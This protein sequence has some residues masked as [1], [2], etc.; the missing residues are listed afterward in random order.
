MDLH[1]LKTSIRINLDISLSKSLWMMV[2]ILEKVLI[3]SSKTCKDSK[4]NL[5]W[6]MRLWLNRCFFP[7]KACLFRINLDSP[8]LNL[9][10]NKALINLIL[11]R[12]KRSLRKI[13]LSKAK[14]I[15]KKLLDKL[16]TQP[17]WLNWVGWW[18]LKDF[19]L[20]SFSSLVLP[21]WCKHLMVTFSKWLIQWL[22]IFI[23][24]S[25]KTMA[26]WDLNQRTTWKKEIT[27]MVLTI[28]TLITNN[29]F[30]SMIP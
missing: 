11:W 13:H 15:P 22:I 7:L 2:S 29:L 18:I 6:V 14:W 3:N 26:I 4:G 12:F 19:R 28:L 17:K 1:C 16:N 24:M 10:C 23:G 21:Q 5:K 27:M 20:N 9:L 25:K 8:D 30:P